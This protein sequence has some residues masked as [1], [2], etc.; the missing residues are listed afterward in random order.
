MSIIK[1][2]FA[3]A[4]NQVATERGISVDEVIESMEAA[5]LAAFKKEY[6]DKFE[7][8]MTVK[9]SRDTGETKV[10]EEG[11]DVTPPGFGRIAAQTARQVILQK[12]REAE[13]KMSSPTLPSSLVRSSKD[14]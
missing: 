7:E 1:S 6:P 8:S 14:A 4:L 5:V 9:V 10:L 2:E 13:K 3:L 12:I 11:K